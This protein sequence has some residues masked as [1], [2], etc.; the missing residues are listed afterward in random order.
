[1]ILAP[2]VRTA[3]KSR[4]GE[5]IMSDKSRLLVLRLVLVVVCVSHLVIGIAI[6]SGNRELLEFA[7]RSYGA[8][9]VP[10]DP[11]FLYILKPL[12]AYMLA[13]GFLAATALYDPLKNRTVVDGIILLLV[14]RVL[15]RAFFRAEV[16]EAF[17]ITG[18]HLVTQ[19]LFFLTIA[20]ALFWFRPRRVTGY[21]N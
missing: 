16:Q 18:A 4:L 1:M 20:V 8:S 11:Q 17:G 6:M 9:N 15:Q 19:S 13:M 10:T 3:G 2:F 5:E 7:G 12:G 14:L 21:S